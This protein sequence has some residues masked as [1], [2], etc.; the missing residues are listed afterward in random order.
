MTAEQWQS[1]WAIYYEAQGLQALS[2]KAFVESSSSDLEVI[3]ELYTLLDLNADGQA[4]ETAAA[5]SPRAGAT[6]GKYEVGSLLGAGGMGEV[7]LTRDTALGR[8]VAL[9]FLHPASL[10]DPVAVKRFVGEARAASALN[11]PN[12]VTVHEVIPSD[13]GLAIAMELVD[14]KSLREYAADGLE[15]ADV[16]QSGRQIALALDAAHTAGVVHRDIKPENIF[17][18]PDGI[19]K[20]L[21][22]GLARELPRADG[23]GAT[24][25]AG[26]PVGT[27]K[28]MSPEQLRGEQIAAASDVF[29]LGIVLYELLTGRHPFA[30]EQLWEVAGA[31]A[32]ADPVRPS[33][34]NAA[35]PEHLDRLILAM[36][37]KNPA[38]RPTAADVARVLAGEQ[39]APRFA[40]IRK[41][42]PLWWVAAA[43]AVCLGAIAA[44]SLLRKTPQEPVFHD[45]TTNAEGNPVLA[46]GIS[47]DGKRFAYADAG[48]LFLRDAAV[49][50]SSVPLSAP[51]D[52]YVER[53]SWAPN[54]RFLVVCGVQQDTSQPSIWMVDPGGA[55]PS[56]IRQGAREGTPSPDGTQIAFTNPDTG[57]LWV[58]P[59]AGGGV[60]QDRKDRVR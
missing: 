43:A 7:Y 10:G 9:K 29:S 28:Y 16:I 37:A 23:A 57:D 8:A 20:V 1:C 25:R 13:F 56:L 11:H 33:R 55:A 19:V 21:D 54:G 34:R 48:G 52:L 17:L 15:V 24:S 6:I 3:E 27:L 18:R 49:G 60:A 5:T 46:A 22:F 50:S 36:L 26:L 41:S 45:L 35:I 31:I 2:R 12:I 53:I 40:R 30:S 39:A 44:I 51:K 47:P 59:L 38:Q 4:G 14:G 32:N 58:A 42:R